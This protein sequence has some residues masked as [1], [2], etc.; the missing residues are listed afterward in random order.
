MRNKYRIQENIFVSKCKSHLQSFYVNGYEDAKERYE[1]ERTDYNKIT[2]RLNITQT[3]NYGFQFKMKIMISC[4][5]NPV[6]SKIQQKHGSRGTKMS[7]E[8]FNI[9]NEYIKLK[10]TKKV[11]NVFFEVW[12]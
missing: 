12:V 3:C 1:V 11:N 4:F 9:Y 8:K 10:L 2:K 5:E 6:T 7:R